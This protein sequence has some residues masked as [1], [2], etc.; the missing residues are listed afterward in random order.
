MKTIYTILFLGLSI[1]LVS[2]QMT[3]EER[4]EKSPRHHEWKDVKYGDRVV[5]TF[6]VYPEVSEAAPA[7]IVIHENRGLNDW[8]RGFA[9]QVAEAGYI[10]VAPDLL[11]GAGVEGAGTASFESSDDARNAI[12]ELDPD[13]VT[14]DLNAVADYAKEIAAANGKVAVIGFCWGGSQSFRF[15]TNTDQIEAAFVCYGTAPK[16]AEDLSRIDVPVYGFYG[17]NDNRVNATIPDT[18]AAMDKLGKVYEPVVYDGAGHGF[19]RAGESADASEDNKEARDAGW[20]RLN[21]LLAKID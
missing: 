15:A 18:E 8:A 3:P 16:E 20:E 2:A 13:Q 17:G 6:V 19:F 10:A 11:W 12:Y 1:T 21:A 9:D 14:A 4:L 5:R 7:I